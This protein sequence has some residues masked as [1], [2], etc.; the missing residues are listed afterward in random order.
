ME[1]VAADEGSDIHDYDWAFEMGIWS[2]W[3]AQE[4]IS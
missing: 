1:V 2:T 4:M 3:S